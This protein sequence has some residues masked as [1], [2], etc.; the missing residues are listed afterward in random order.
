MIFSVLVVLSSC[1]FQTSALTVPKDSS[2][3]ANLE[4]RGT[5]LK[6]ARQ[7]D[8]FGPVWKDIF[9][10]CNQIGKLGRT[11]ERAWN[12]H[13][14]AA[15]KYIGLRKDTSLPQIVQA[16]AELKAEPP[17][18]RPFINSNRP[19]SRPFITKSRGQSTPQ[20][21]SVSFLIIIVI[22][23]GSSS[24]RRKKKSSK[25]ER[26]QSNCKLNFYLILIQG[27]TTSDLIGRTLHGSVFRGD[28]LPH[29]IKIDGIILGQSSLLRS[30]HTSDIGSYLRAAARDPNVVA[31]AYQIQTGKVFVSSG[32]N[33][34]YGRFT[35]YILKN[36][37]L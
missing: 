23:G 14:T 20:V 8:L 10:T 21:R 35:T 36:K 30:E 5:Q 9:G 28:A 7:A 13:G 37:A 11:T 25:I 34:R 1:A 12:D 32:I 27:G 3:C 33:M 31:V 26:C 29:W 18:S 6:G 4:K 2:D 15:K 22:L 17:Q 19:I 16:P 24:P